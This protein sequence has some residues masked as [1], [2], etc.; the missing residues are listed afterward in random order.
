[1]PFAAILDQLLSVVIVPSLMGYDERSKEL[2]EIAWGHA[3]EAG[4][5]VEMNNRAL[6]D[7]GAWCREPDAQIW[8][9]RGQWEPDWVHTLLIVDR[10]PDPRGPQHHFYA[11]PITAG[12]S[13]FRA[14]V[15]A[16]Y[17]ERPGRPGQPKEQWLARLRDDGVYVID[18]VTRPIVLPDEFGAAL[19]ERGPLCAQQAHELHPDGVV[20]CGEA[21]FHALSHTGLPV[22]HDVPIPL[23]TSRAPVQFISE[24]RRAL[25]L[26]R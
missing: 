13:L 9:A 6:I 22:L 23:P 4:L 16:L 25:K 5:R 21:T 7:L 19:G 17:R 3:N 12:D 2:R 15:E 10:V 20:L 26:V 24:L 14:V 1:M 11:E 18:L 8:Y